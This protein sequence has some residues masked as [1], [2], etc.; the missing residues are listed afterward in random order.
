MPAST[1]SLERL[2]ARIGAFLSD[3]ALEELMFL[4]KAELEGRD[5]DELHVSVTPDRLDLL[6][7]AGLA[8]HL[9]GAMGVAEGI[10]RPPERGGGSEIRCDI[11]PSVAALRP[12]FAAVLVESSE[13]GGLDEGTLAEAIRFQ[14]LL[15]AT[16]GRDRRLASLGIY[17][18][19]R[20]EFPL[21][22]SLEAMEAVR[23]V[24]LDG[25]EE[26]AAARFFAEHPMAA[27]YGS[28][29]RSGDR[30][31][32][33]RDARGSVLSLPPVLNAR[34]AGEARPGDRRL[35][36]ESTGASPRAVGEALGLL[37][38]VFV[39]RGWTVGP[40]RTVGTGDDPGVEW[41]RPRT[42][43]L[44]VGVLH[45]IAGESLSSAEVARRLAAARLGGHPHRA[46]WS[47]EVPP[48]RPDLLTAVDLA[49]DVILAGGVRP[50]CG[51]L[52]PS[53]TR[54]R[55]RP[56]SRFR[57]RIRRRLLGMGLA[58]PYTP[59]LV[60][61]ATARRMG[62]DGAIRLRNPV[63]AEFAVLRDRLLL[64]HIEVLER[65]TRHPYP[66]RFGEVGPVVCPDPAAESG[67]ETRY[68]A[69]IVL[70][71][72][73]TGFADG[74]ARVEML[75]RSFDVG[76]VREPAVLSGTIPGRAASFRVAGEPVAETAE[77][78]PGVLTELGVPVPTTWAELD[79]TALWALGARRDT[80]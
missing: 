79:L 31:L 49:E 39:G 46:G 50:E 27:R 69:S 11:D 4:S 5:G 15:H 80:H 23:F 42:V 25:T 32:T 73:G 59:L 66:Q 17:P 75:L 24:P 72:D 28:L 52:P 53:P 13:E 29:G 65:N 67:A 18:L 54:G 55:R 36:L 78:H 70:A 57:G 45:G 14:E 41:Y 74:A 6:S 19:D 63:S 16:V 8:L 62:A 76:F 60:G 68:H 43:D 33:L 9:A 30:T 77:I 38:V 20:I 47:V 26:V 64:S 10:L 48:W 2:R 71:E 51:V 58:Q 21:R 12:S 35:L 37:E 3:S 7:E 22:Y 61:E 56:E 40:V 1:L 44:P 34:G